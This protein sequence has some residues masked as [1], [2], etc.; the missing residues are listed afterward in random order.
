MRIHNVLKNTSGFAKAAESALKWRSMRDKAEVERRVKILTF[1]QK[2]G[3]ET[4]KD[5]FGVG[6]ATLYR[7]QKEL[8]DNGG[9]IQALDPKSRAPK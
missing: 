1:W 4:T 6:R 9:T 8:N 7:W 3:T 5:A 2:H